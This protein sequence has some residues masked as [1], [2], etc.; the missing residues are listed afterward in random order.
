VVADSFGAEFPEFAEGLSEAPKEGDTGGGYY[1]KVEVDGGDARVV[2]RLVNNKNEY[3]LKD[4]KPYRDNDPL[5][6]KD[7]TDLDVHPKL[8]NGSFESGFDGWLSTCRFVADKDPGWIVETSP[9]PGGEGAGAIVQVREQGQ[10]WASNPE[11]MEM[12]QMVSI[13]PSGGLFEASYYME[14]MPKQG[15]GFIRLSL[16]SGP[17]LK[18]IM[19]FD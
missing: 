7:V 14:K 13:P 17:E 16:Y 3:V 19:H 15:G 8:V 12:Y 18:S 4:Y 6:F 10:R 1:I 11:V 9:N 5:W 2:C